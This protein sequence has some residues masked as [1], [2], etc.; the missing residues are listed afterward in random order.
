MSTRATVRFATR[1]AGVSFNEHPKEW[2]AQFY[3]HFDGYPEGLG[4]DIAYSVTKN[5]KLAGWE[6]EHVDHV[7]GDL[8]YVYY[9][10]QDK[11]KDM[12]ISIF[13]V[14]GWPEGGKCVFVGKPQD[15]LDKYLFFKEAKERADQFYKT[16]KEFYKNHETKDC[17]SGETCDGRGCDKCLCGTT[18]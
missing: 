17:F 3:V 8:E 5:T 18:N 16:A 13:S 11:G 15:L 1:K 9:V 4:V 6:L 12:W 10:W 14:S 2:H 7:H